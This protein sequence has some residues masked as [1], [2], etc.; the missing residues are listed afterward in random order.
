MWWN[1]KSSK[2]L[3]S[4]PFNILHMARQLCCRGV[5]KILLRSDHR[6]LN[7]NK[8][9]FPSN[10]NCEQNTVDETGS[11]LRS[12]ERHRWPRL[13]SISGVSVLSNRENVIH[14]GCTVLCLPEG[15]FGQDIRCARKYPR[16]RIGRRYHRVICWIIMKIFTKQYRYVLHETT[17]GLGGRSLKLISP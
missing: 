13:A 15:K 6:W 11:K 3:Q 14:Q 16:S 4:D 5:C 7:Y 9:K 8:A 12:H 2:C 1:F 10:L 17:V